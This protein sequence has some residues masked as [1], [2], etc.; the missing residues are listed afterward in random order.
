MHMAVGTSLATIIVTSISSIMAH[1]QRGAVLWDVVRNLAPG[2]VIG[3]F[4]G[5]GIADYLS[6]QGL[7]LLIG[8]F[9]VWIAFR[10]FRGAHY[11]VDPNQKLPSAALQL[12][13]GG[14]IGVAS[15][16]FGIGGGSLTVPFLNRCGVVIQKA[17]ATS[18]ACGLPIAVA[19]ALG[20]IWFGQK[21]E[22]EVPNTIGYIHIYAFIGISV[23]SF[24]TAK[25]GA[26]VAH[27]LSPVLLKMFCGLIDYSW[28]VFYL[29]R[30][31][32]LNYSFLSAKF[33]RR[34]GHYSPFLDWVGCIDTRLSD[35]VKVFSAKS[36]LITEK[37]SRM[38]ALASIK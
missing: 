10:M 30:L 14:G 26:K 11:Q 32:C 17:V 4:L 38:T 34:I 28:S 27:L 25:F 31:Y 21:A 22:V 19:G 2:L 8:F 33:L 37:S 5:A 13:A 7:Q 20:F 1:H 12:A 16:I 3:S 23:M 35:N 6:G 18:A 36:R 9:A 29:S 15:A 24:I